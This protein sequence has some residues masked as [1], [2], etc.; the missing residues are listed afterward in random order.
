M[1]L[2]NTHAQ[3]SRIFH[4]ILENKI[5]IIIYLKIAFLLYFEK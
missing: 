3:T 5:K 4:G 1:V 2:F